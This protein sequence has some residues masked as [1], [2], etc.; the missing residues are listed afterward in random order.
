MLLSRGP[1]RRWYYCDGAPD[2]VW[3]FSQQ[4]KI[5]KTKEY[6]AR[7]ETIDPPQAREKC[8]SPGVSV[9]LLFSPLELPSAAA[10]AVVT[11]A[12]AAAAGGRRNLNENVFNSIITVGRDNEERKRDREGDRKRD[13]E[14]GDD[15]C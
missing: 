12:A 13:R 8:L 9:C 6:K 4:Q 11:A 14:D 1:L 5:T 2:D 3:V 10:V 7:G 15:K